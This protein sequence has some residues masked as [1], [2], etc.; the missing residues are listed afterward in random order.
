M[1]RMRGQ[2]QASKLLFHAML[3][4]C[5]QLPASF[6][7]CW[8][9]GGARCSTC[10]VSRE[11]FGPGALQAHLEHRR[12]PKSSALTSLLLQESAGTENFILC[13]S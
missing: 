8:L 2:Q 12:E 4:P 10:P 7:V 6:C 1:E 13:C 3:L 5:C 9:L 11:K